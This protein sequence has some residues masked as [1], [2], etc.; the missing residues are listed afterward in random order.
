VLR[1]LPISAYRQ[2]VI[3]MY[4]V[5]HITMEA[6]SKQNFLF[7]NTEITTQSTTTENSDLELFGPHC[8]H[9][10]ILP[11]KRSWLRRGFK[12]EY[13]YFRLLTIPQRFGKPPKP[14]KHAPITLITR[15]GFVSYQRP[16]LPNWAR[17]PQL[18]AA[19]SC[20][21]VT[22]IITWRHMVF[23]V[24][25]AAVAT[26]SPTMMQIGRWKYSYVE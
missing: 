14:S 21:R 5:F 23:V 9:L 22:S 12:M 15:S 18:A 13:Y 4:D 3:K 24:S 2:I 25:A 8:N 11:L 20:F 6:I 7:K 17:I 19:T 16:Y 26:L 1:A 10:H